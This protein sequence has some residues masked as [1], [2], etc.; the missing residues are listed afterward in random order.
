MKLKPIET[1]PED[2]TIILIMGG[3]CIPEINQNY[4]NIHGVVAYNIDVEE[5]AA[6]NS[7]GYSLTI[8][9]PTHWCELPEV[10]SE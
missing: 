4:P 7:G 8:M 5:W 3:M 9:D 2:G 6:H 1:A 10:P